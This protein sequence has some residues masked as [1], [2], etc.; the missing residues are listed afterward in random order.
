M[1]HYTDLLQT[2]DGAWELAWASDE[3]LRRDA[4]RDRCDL[5]LATPA[6][7]T[8]KEILAHRLPTVPAAVPGNFELD[9]HRAGLCPDPFFGENALEMQKYECMHQYYS[10]SFSFSGER[11]GTVLL[12]EGIDTAAEIFLNGSRIYECE[13][14]FVEHCIDI[15]KTLR[16]GENELVVHIKPATVYARRYGGADSTVAQH[17]NHSSL[18][19]RKAAGMF[20]WDILPRIVSGGIWRSVTLGRRRPTRLC[21]LY[22]YTV[23]VNRKKNTARLFFSYEIET[24]LDSLSDMTLEVTGACGESRFSKTLRL[25]HTTGSFIH[26]VN[27]PKLWMPKNYG[28]ANLYHITA[29]LLCGDEELDRIELDMGIRTVTLDRTS[30]IEPDGTRFGKGQ[31]RFLINGEP[32]FAMGTNWVPL[33]AFHSRDRERL[34]A[35]LPMLTD[36][37]CNMIRLWGGNVYEHEELFDF[38]DRQGI[39]I[40]Q[41]FAMGCGVYP[42]DGGFARRLRSE[43]EQIVQKYRNHPS[44]AL[45][46][47]DNEC[48]IFARPTRDPN[49]NRLTREL[50]PDVLARLDI[51]RPYLPSSP[52]VDETAYRT[53]LPTSEEHTW[54]PRDYFKGSYYRGTVCRF[55]SEVGYHGCPSPASL[56]KFMTADALKGGW[57]ERAGEDIAK[58]E[59]LVHATCPDPTPDSPYAYRIPLMARQ[60]RTLFGEEPTTPDAFAAAS[61]ISQAEA[62]KF[63]IESFRI[64]REVRTGVLW[65]NLIDGWP[66]ISDAVV[67]YYSERKLAYAYIRRAQAPLAVMC[68]EPRE[69]GIPLCGVSDLTHPAA[70]KWSLRTLGEAEEFRIGGESVLLPHT[71]TAL[72]TLPYTEGESRFYLMEWEYTAPD[73]SVV[74]GKNHYV[75][76]MEQTL[77]LS[78]YIQ[79]MKQAGFCGDAFFC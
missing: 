71:A 45:W 36:L 19:L 60:V 39:L 65:W 42:Q 25:W 63:F 41:D 64:Q 56:K 43:A 76:G 75:S 40:W 10:R 15:S 47:G 22:A 66:Q 9:L 57:R 18:H 26:L 67:D 30:V 49:T 7:S 23:K 17:Y 74:T 78:H 62:K 3:R 14:M 72:A 77:N 4:L 34:A 79:C 21:D 38:C 31:F 6:L 16:E 11:E 54:G 44:L 37:G 27:E 53:G 50:L 73:G 69:G 8:R 12:F 61:Q 33:D 32:I 55:V 13:N 29:R 5:T 48:D 46:A 28:D 35:V 24:D 2:L 59:W 20:G 70:V 51:S 68:D 1:K 58:R 52:Y